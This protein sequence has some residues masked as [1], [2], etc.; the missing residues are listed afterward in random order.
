[1]RLQLTTEPKLKFNYYSFLNIIINTQLKKCMQTCKLHIMQLLNELL[2]SK[3]CGHWRLAWGKWNSTWHLVYKLFYWHLS[4]VETLID[5]LHEMFVHV[6]FVLKLVVKRKGWSCSAVVFIQRSVTPHQRAPKRYL[7]FEFPEQNWH[8]LKDETI[9]SVHM[10]T[11]PKDPTFF[12]TN[13]TCTI[14]TLIYIVLFL[15]QYYHYTSKIKSMKHFFLSLL[16]SRCNAVHINS[17]K[18]LHLCCLM[19]FFS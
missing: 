15:S 11:E 10:H 16:I 1:M 7:L 8:N 5:W 19:L 17:C 13:N 9:C 2:N 18:L 4:A 6:Y 12:G 3:S 14:T